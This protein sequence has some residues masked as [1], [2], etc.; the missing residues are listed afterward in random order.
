MDHVLQVA[1]LSVSKSRKPRGCV[2]S[3]LAKRK[4][5]QALLEFHRMLLLQIQHIGGGFY[6]RDVLRVWFRRR[7]ANGMLK[8][9]QVGN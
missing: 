5:R 8:R 3:A 1:P 4:S 2:H 9:L 6:N 7:D